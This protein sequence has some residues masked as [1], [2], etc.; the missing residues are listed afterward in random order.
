[1]KPSERIKEIKNELIKKDSLLAVTTL[2]SMDYSFSAIYEY[3]DGFFVP[4][5][6]KITPSK[7]CQCG[8]GKKCEEL[9]R[10]NKRLIENFK[11]KNKEIDNLKIKNLGMFNKLREIRSVMEGKE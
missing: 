5:E 10:E 1:M 9:E 2:Q 3:L 8:L 7:Q 11:R 6:I 4:G